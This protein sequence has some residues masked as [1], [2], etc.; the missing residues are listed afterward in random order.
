[1]PK[2]HQKIGFVGAGNMGQ[3]IIGALIKS[4]CSDP[5][6]I[7][8]SD[9]RQNQ[10]S[11]LKKT[12]DIN[13][14]SSNAEVVEACDVIIF[15]VKPQAIDQVLSDLLS[16]YNMDRSLQRKL[17]ISI[18]AGTRLKKIED[19]L[20]ASLDVEKRKQMPIL[21]VMP[22]TPALVMA[23]MSGVCA[24]AYATHKDMQVAKTI[25]AA[26]GRVIEFQEKDMDAVTAMSGS[27][28]AYCFYL[29]EAMID[30]GIKLG[31]D[32]QIAA[33]MTIT[34]LK[35]ALVLLESQKESA[36]ALRKR[37][38]SP[39]GTTEAAISVMDD[40]A[41]KQTITKAVIAAAERSKAL[42]E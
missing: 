15:A 41:V 30:A 26:M 16:D 29:V 6:D 17:F 12:Y 8:V 7:F 27:G 18:A 14:L 21:R 5:F 35:G 33:E 1:M 11:V 20:Y 23:G 38:T 22:N 34:T 42:S 37:V 32:K 10:T 13:I 31:I 24:N 3:A 36:E 28:P 2:L 4:K 40:K 39:G 9:I 19:Y 25:L